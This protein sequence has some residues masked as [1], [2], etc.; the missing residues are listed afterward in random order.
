MEVVQGLLFGQVLGEF[1]RFHCPCSLLTAGL[2]WNP[3]HHGLIAKLPITT[4]LKSN[5]NKM[6]D[7]GYINVISYIC[8]D[9][10]SFIFS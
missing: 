2:W 3:L 4:K 10:E 8:F 7:Y 9:I 5:T 1:S 6:D